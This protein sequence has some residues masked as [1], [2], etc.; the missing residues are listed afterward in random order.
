MSQPMAGHKVCFDFLK[1]ILKTERLLPVRRPAL[2]NGRAGPCLLM[3]WG[4][5]L[6]P[7]WLLL[8]PSLAFACC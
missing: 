5:V 2:R 3:I 8:F 4:E 6:L 1:F 7:K